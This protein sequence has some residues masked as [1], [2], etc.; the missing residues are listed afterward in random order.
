MADVKAKGIVPISLAKLQFIDRAL[1]MATE[2]FNCIHEYLDLIDVPR[3][4]DDGS[5]LTA[6]GRVAYLVGTIRGDYD[7]VKRIGRGTAH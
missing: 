4:D 2:D 6:S 1:A 3:E 7:Q 5:R